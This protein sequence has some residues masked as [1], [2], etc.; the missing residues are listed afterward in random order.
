MGLR[1]YPEY[2][3][4]GV[5]WLGWIPAHWNCLPHRALFDEIVRQG[6]IREELLS[7][8]ISRGVMQQSDLL[9]NSSKKDSS[10]LDKSKYKLVEPGDIAYNKMRAWQGAVG[11]SRHRGIVSP[12]Y[13]VNRPRSGNM[14]EYFHYLFRTPGFAK[15]AERWSYGITSD[16][17]SLRSQHFKMIY[18]CVPPYQ[19]QVSIV[20]YLNHLNKDICRFIRN[21]RR[22]IAVLNEQ[23]QA[24]INRAVT[25]GIKPEVPLKPSGID[26]VGDIPEHWN[27][28]RMKQLAKVHTGITLGKNYLDKHLEE[29]PYL[30]VA[31]VQTDRLDL[32]L[33]KT[34][35]IPPSE[36]AGSELMPGDV[37]MTE[38]GDID[39]LARGCVWRGEIKGCLHQNHIFAVRLDQRQLKPDYLV[40]LMASQHGRIY[41]ELTAKRTTN[42]A[43]TNKTTLG[44]FPL[45]L[46]DI[47]EQIQILK[48]INEETREINALLDRTDREISLIQQYRSRLIAEVVTGKIDVR[49][50]A[51]PSG[52]I[53][54]QDLVEELEPIEGEQVDLDQEALAGEIEE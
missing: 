42:L 50:L 24:I 43:S 7:V 35:M 22:L 47:E 52:S 4:S 1:V 8:T 33:V 23:K 3:D 44:A 21:R 30:R 40:A 18:S 15:E 37:L 11:V 5:P 34:V 16:Q 25:R 13:I 38:G 48:F 36:I 28:V 45:V 19:E 6:H 39:K 9:Q 12:A 26:W 29:R 10:N 2:K 14:P 20:R 53:E 54:A 31:N 17:W 27:F 46:P 32:R 51:P 49:H 41:F